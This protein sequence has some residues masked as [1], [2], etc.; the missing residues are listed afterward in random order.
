MQYEVARKNKEA[1]KVRLEMY[2]EKM[3]KQK[4]RKEQK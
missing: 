1:L 4:K 3:Q 2:R